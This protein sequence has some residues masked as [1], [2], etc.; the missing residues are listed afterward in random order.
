MEVIVV[1][2]LLFFGGWIF[3]AL[4]AATKAAVRSTTGKGTFEGN[5]KAAFSG[6]QPLESRLTRR[7]VSG[8]KS[9]EV[10]DIEVRGLIPVERV[11]RLGAVGAIL[12]FTELGPDGKPIRQ[13]VI[14][15]LEDFQ[16]GT[17]RCYQHKNEI[18]EVS[19]S[20]GFVD[21]V[22]IVSVIPETLI[23]ARRGKRTFKFFMMFTDLHSPP[24][25]EHGFRVQGETVKTVVH[26]FE[27]NVETKGYEEEVESKEVTEEVTLQLAVA[28]AYADG[29]FA[30][31]EGELLKHWM[32]RRVSTVSKAR[33]DARKESLNNAFRDAFTKA[34]A[35]S[36]S[37]GPL[38][39]KLK[40]HADVAERVEAVEL[41]LDV[42][43]ADGHASDE[44]LHKVNKIAE[45]LEVDFAKFQQ[46]RDKRLL[47]TSGIHQSQGDMFALL[48]I[49]RAWSKDQIR[50][51]LN[52]LYAQWNSRAEALHDESKRADAERML[53]L[54]ATAR[55]QLLDA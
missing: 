38:V 11:T 15:L 27:W 39:Q 53:E 17:S 22:R 29:H 21:W 36:L 44:E 25:F 7:T 2:V 28:M 30:A 37:I 51:H 52:K 49:D 34:K 46:L 20:T 54:I 50:T 14:S 45:Q 24:E 41:C 26:E 18:G 48:N 16:E 42:M 32:V 8:H 40:A 1:L 31:K 23:T 35:G 19:P 55:K 9:F 47:G 3:R 33:R 4:T 43:S 12:D 5:F 13:P 10:L 6:M